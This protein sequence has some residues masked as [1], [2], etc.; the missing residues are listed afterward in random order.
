M[1]DAKRPTLRPEPYASTSIPS[2]AQAREVPF[3][4]PSAL[5]LPYLGIPVVQS[6]C[7]ACLCAV[8]F[9][10][11]SLQIA[12]TLSE[13]PGQHRVEG[14]CRVVFCSPDSDAS[15]DPPE[16]MTLEAYWRQTGVSEEAW[17]AAGEV[18]TNDRCCDTSKAGLFECIITE[19]GKLKR[20]AC[21]SALWSFPPPSLSSGVL[22]EQ[23]PR[24]CWGH[25]QKQPQDPTNTSP[26]WGFP[27]TLSIWRRASMFASVSHTHTHA[28]SH[29]RSAGMKGI[30][31]MPHG[32]VVPH[33]PPGQHAG[34]R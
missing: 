24:F 15:T 33:R 20:T 22:P 30:A 6:R 10:G 26:S 21:S 18:F 27:S 25:L 12:G 23:A 1:W 8:W 5:L 2:W 28:H 13:L 29:G 3:P 11:S 7:R 16:D 17:K 4:F 9:W 31:H 14:T 32:A 19:R 34:V